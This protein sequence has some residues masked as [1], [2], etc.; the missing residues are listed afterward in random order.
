MGTDS[1]ALTADAMGRSRTRVPAFS[2]GSLRRKRMKGRDPRRA[3]G[4]GLLEPDLDLKDPLALTSM[5][6]VPLEKVVANGRGLQFDAA[7]VMN[8]LAGKRIA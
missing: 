4:L 3:D 1:G 7:A 6:L 8:Q 5:A 2:R